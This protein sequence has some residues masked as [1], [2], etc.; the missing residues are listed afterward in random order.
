MDAKT[1]RYT[2]LLAAL[3]MV[4]GLFGQQAP[5]VAHH[6]HHDHDHHHHGNANISFIENAGQWEKNILYKTSTGGINT[7]YLEENNL[8]YSF[9]HSEDLE[10]VHD[11]IYA[12]AEDQEAHIIRRHAYKVHFKNARSPRLE[13]IDKNTA[14]HNYILGNDPDKWASH[15]SLYNKINSLLSSISWNTWRTVTPFIFRLNFVACE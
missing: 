11:L 1:Y 15:V 10:K 8:T 7:I 12:T 6:H 13:G 4:V 3:L 2:L 9:A 14:Y 5:I